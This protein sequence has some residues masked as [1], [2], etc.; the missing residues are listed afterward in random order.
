MSEPE[1]AK[2]PEEDW[3]DFWEVRERTLSGRIV[4]WARRRFLTPALVRAIRENSERGT[5]VEAGCGSGQV[6][7]AIAA[8]RGDTAVLV[9][10]SERALAIARAGAEQ[11]GVHASFVQCDIAEL[12]SHVRGDDTTTVFNIGVVEHFDDCSDLLR[13]MA[14]VG[15]RA[16]IALV[17]ARSPFWL[18][19]YRL[20]LALKLIPHDLYVR[21]YR[22]AELLET[23]ERAGLRPMHSIRLRVLGII[24]YIGACFRA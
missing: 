3:D 9:D 24:P 16:A 22:E 8:E 15:R 11:L 12:S 18:F 4:N 21:Y 17:P 23:V 7:L 20:S 13:E 6:I 2:G 14:R 5:L 19:F 10:R 1:S